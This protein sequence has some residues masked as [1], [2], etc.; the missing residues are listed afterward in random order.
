MNEELKLTIELVPKTSWYESL[1]E[2]MPRAE[3]DRLRKRTYAA[4]GQKCGI[5]DAKGRLNCHEIWEYD[6][7]NHVQK[8]EGFITL[9]NM[10]HFV[11]HIGFA[12]ILAQNGKLDYGKVVEHFMEVNQCDR[13]T[14]E[15]HREKAFAQWR[16]RSTHE[17]EVDLGECEELIKR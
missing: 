13:A 1:R 3:W 12:G 4:Y 6:D 16:E 11:K 10:C 9:C 5:C 17:W 14:F 7:H 2:E 15:E 8:L